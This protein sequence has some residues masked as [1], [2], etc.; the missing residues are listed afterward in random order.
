MPHPCVHNNTLYYIVQ[1]FKLWKRIE[2]KW[3]KDNG[4]YKWKVLV[5]VRHVVWFDICCTI[6]RG[7]RY[8]AFVAS[9]QTIQHTDLLCQ[10]YYLHIFCELFNILLCIYVIIV[11]FKI[12]KSSSLNILHTVMHMVYSNNF[13]MSFIYYYYYN[14]N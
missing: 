7:S 6:S 3:W 4:N 10:H 11:W 8:S 12:K 2:M 13:V 1:Y 14:F 9:F 5:N